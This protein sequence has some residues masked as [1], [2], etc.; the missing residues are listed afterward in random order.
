[1]RT[2]IP[3]QAASSAA[4]I[5][6]R[7]GLEPV[8]DVGAD[9]Q[10]SPLTQFVRVSCPYCGRGYDSAVDL[11]AGTQDTIEDCQ[12]CCC[13]IALA[14]VVSEGVLQQVTARRLDEA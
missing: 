3:D 12:H 2:P 4:A 1:M 14:I 11:T 13:S 9:R 6:R 8:L 10:H 7:Y 5:D